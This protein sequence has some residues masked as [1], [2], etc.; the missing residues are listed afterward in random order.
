MRSDTNID[1]DRDV[2]A[3]EVVI[4]FTHSQGGDRV[5]P[6]EVLEVE[7]AFRNELFGTF[8]ALDFAQNTRPPVVLSEAEYAEVLARVAPRFE[9]IE[10]EREGCRVRLKRVVPEEV[11]EVP[12][13]KVRILRGKDKM[14]VARL[15][16]VL[17]K[18]KRSVRD[19][20]NI[21]GQR[22]FVITEAQLQ[23]IKDK[24]MV[25]F[26]EV[27]MLDP[28]TFPPEEVIFTARPQ[29]QSVEIPKEIDQLRAQYSGEY[30]EGT[31]QAS[32]ISKTESYHVE[33]TK[34]VNRWIRE[35]LLI[36]G[37][38]GRAHLVKFRGTTF[39]KIGG[40]EYLGEKKEVRGL[41]D[42]WTMEQLLE[43]KRGIDERVRRR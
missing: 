36:S 26:P 20:C 41:D 17:R 8:S 7:R 15:R 11:P 24:I 2:G 25:D 4:E 6:A 10:L 37:A 33:L 1:L 35:K 32:I 12:T 27:V 38:S 13:I 21:V 19:E 18:F 34:S 39:K 31:I 23:D 9:G 22:D 5:V 40:F 29:P 14:P 43:W 16:T 3:E 30:H 28:E 42:P